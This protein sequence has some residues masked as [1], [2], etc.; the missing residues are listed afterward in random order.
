[1]AAKTT[2]ADTKASREIETVI[3]KKRDFR[4]DRGLDLDIG[5][6]SCDRLR[7]FSF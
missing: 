5:F 6:L 2:T 7:A 4:R 1:M 3:R